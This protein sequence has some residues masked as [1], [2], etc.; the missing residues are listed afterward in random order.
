MA[1]SF[2]SL[3]AGASGRQG[4][5]DTING[6]QQNQADQAASDNAQ[7]DSVQDSLARDRDR[8]LRMFSTQN[9]MRGGVA[10]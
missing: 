3:T 9:L 6:L 8:Y 4:R 10:R 5:I 2:S 7:A 1:K